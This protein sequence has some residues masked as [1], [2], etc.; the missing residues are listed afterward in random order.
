MM[1]EHGNSKKYNDNI[2]SRFKNKSNPEIIIVVD[3]LLT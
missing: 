1:A 2:I 3:K